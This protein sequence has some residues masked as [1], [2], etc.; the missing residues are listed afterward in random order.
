MHLVPGTVVFLIAPSE[1]KRRRGVMS[2]A[3]T[4]ERCV[5][6]RC[7]GAGPREAECVGECAHPCDFPA[8]CE[9]SALEA[10]SNCYRSLA[11]DGADGNVDAAS[12]GAC[13][14]ACGDRVDDYENH[15]SFLDRGDG[16]CDRCG[17]TIAWHAG[18]RCFCRL[19]DGMP[20]PVERLQLALDLGAAWA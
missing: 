9:L 20:A 2:T 7:L 1:R 5:W 3:A 17:R 4:D 10:A 8:L 19:A 11:I 14:A 16:F 15:G 18:R 12:D 6:P 13:C